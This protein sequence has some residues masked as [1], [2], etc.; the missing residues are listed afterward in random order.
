MDDDSAMLGSGTSSASTSVADLVWL[1]SSDLSGTAYPRPDRFAGYR[2]SAWKRSADQPIAIDKR[3][4]LI[5]AIFSN[6]S[7]AEAVK[8]LCREDAQ[9]FVDV[10]DE[11]LPHSS[12]RGEWLTDLTSRRVDI[13]ECGT[14]A[15]EEVREHAVQDMW[16]PRFAS[17]SIPNP[18]LFRPIGASTMQRRVCRCV[19][20]QSSRS[21][22][23]S[24][25]PESILDGRFQ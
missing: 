8:C 17:E 21:Q 18:A 1:V 4:S 15:E 6:R 10:V 2:I 13:G 14:A 9:A 19:D 11:V 22:G 25:G 24:Q 23:R 20:G 16:S 3:I 12:I 7:V 5:T